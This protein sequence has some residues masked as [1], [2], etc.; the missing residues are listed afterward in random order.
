MRIPLHGGRS[1]LPTGLAGSAVT[2]F[3][4]PV[5]GPLLAVRTTW[6]PRLGLYRR[7]GGVVGRA[8]SEVGLEPEG[9]PLV[10]LYGGFADGTVDQLLAAEA[11][12][13]VRTA[14]AETRVQI[15]DGGA[16]PWVVALPGREY[17]LG[18][19]DSGTT[20]VRRRGG[21]GVATSTTKAR[22]RA[23]A[24]AADW[25]GLLTVLAGPGLVFAPEGAGAPRSALFVEGADDA[26]EEALLCLLGLHALVGPVVPS[27]VRRRL[28]GPVARLLDEGRAHVTASRPGSVEEFWRTKGPQTAPEVERRGFRPP[29]TESPWPGSS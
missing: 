24:S 5:N 13:V 19:P 17:E 11:P 29:W 14:E 16:Q 6:P 1:R 2:A 15:P 23:L 4:A 18:S 12:F 10:E 3:D 25:A 8:A 9:L 22:E 27:S 26:A 28:P 20:V 7:R 21:P